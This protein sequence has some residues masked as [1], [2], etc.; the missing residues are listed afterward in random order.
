MEANKIEIKILLLS[1]T[2]IIAVETAASFVISE[3]QIQPIVI[4]GAVRLVETALMILMITT[5]G[6]GMSSIGLAP[7]KMTSGL[8]KGLIWSA[9]VGVATAVTF[10]L[11]FTF[12]IHPLSLIQVNMPAKFEGIFL[13]LCIGGV[14]SPIA[15]EVFFRGILFGFFRRWGF[16]A[17]MALSTL[18]FV[19]V[20]PGVSGFPFPQ[21]A[22]GVLFAMAYEKGKSLMVPI[23]VHVL[24]NTAIFILSLLF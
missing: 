24:G 14:V 4:L 19:V 18:I 8:I 3:S 17:A 16:W 21:F 11:L 1:L 10:V 2:S 13:F 15:E 12:G 22:G 6:K 23:T 9:G 20:H 5:W 7:S